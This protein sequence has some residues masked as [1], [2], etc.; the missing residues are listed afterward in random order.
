MNPSRAVTRAKCV[1][2]D[3]KFKASRRDAAYCSGACRQSAARARAAT[4]EIDREITEARRAYWALIRCKAEAEGKS[5]SQVMTA[6]AHFIDEHGNVYTG[7]A[8]GGLL[9]GERQ[10]VGRTKPL[11]PGWSVWGLEAAGPPFNP[12]LRE[13]L[14]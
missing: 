5:T 7:G 9:E 3:R 14:K 2:C 12:P 1:V 6:Q 8:H 4:S 13:G 11:R 10:L